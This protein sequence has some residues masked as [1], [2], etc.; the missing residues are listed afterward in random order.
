MRRDLQA[1]PHL[2][3]DWDVDVPAL[4]STRAGGVSRGA[5]E[6]LNLSHGVGDDPAAVT[7]NRERVQAQFGTPITPLQ[8]LHGATVVQLQ[9]ANVGAHMPIADA[10]W[11]REPGVGCA[12]TVADCL[13][14]LFGTPDGRAVAAAHAGWRGLALGVLEATV[15]ALSKG[16][17]CPS[18]EL[19]AW[20]GPC[21]GPLAFEVGEDVLQAFGADP[22]APGARFRFQPRDDGSARWRADLPALARDRLQ[23]AGV[24]R[25]SGG[26]RCTFSDRSRFFSF[27]RDRICGRMVAA[28]RVAGGR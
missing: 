27:R 2:R 14:V 4:M 7:I 5:F 19:R 10:A 25:I 1:L 21:I 22:A 15:A 6:S 28:I 24:T 23:A 12:V 20:L 16:A 13:P 11:T 3:P 9:A 26:D 8:L 17:G 18:A